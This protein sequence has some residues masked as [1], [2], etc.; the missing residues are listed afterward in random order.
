[1]KKFSSCMI[2]LIALSS[3]CF[4]KAIDEY[5]KEAKDH[6]E[7]GQYDQAIAT[8]EKAVKEYPKSS[9]AHFQ[10][11]LFIGEKIQ[12]MSDFG[13]MTVLFE[14]LFGAWAKAIALDPK[15]FKARMYRGIWAVSIPKFAGLLDQGIQDL[16]FLAQI[17]EKAPDPSAQKQLVT[18]YIHLADGYQKNG[19]Y[20]KA[21]GLFKKII[22][23][24]PGTEQAGNAKQS[25]DNIIAAEKWQTERRKKVKLDS[26]QVSELRKKLDAKPNNPDL[27]MAL[28]S[29]YFDAQDYETAREYLYNVIEIDSKNIT[30]YKLLAE[31]TQLVLS[32]EYDPRIHLDTDF[33]TDLAFEVAR[34]L[35]EAVTVAPHDI[36]LRL[37]RGIAGVNMPFFV[38]KLD[39]AIEDLKIV[40]ESDAPDSLKAESLYWLGFAYRKKSSTHWIK[41]VSK[42]SD[43]DAARLVFDEITP[44]VKRIDLTTYKTPLLVI[45]FILGFQDELA[46][47]TAVW[48]RD[49][50][51]N[52]VKTV[53][54]SGFSGYAKEQQ[55]NLPMWAHSS[56][57]ADVDAVTGASIDLG[58]HIYV[59]DL[60]NAS[61]KEVK[62]GEYEVLVEVSYWPSMQYQRVSAPIHLGRKE[63]RKVVKEGNLIPYLEVKYIP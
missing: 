42:Y 34:I 12:K 29:I 32:E 61:G 55:V 33:R 2:I 9:E 28:A 10:L 44:T 58:H 21:K 22:E 16:E 51:G 50:D 5:V 8:M 20:E 43:T 13:E 62:S 54:V 41:I 47:Q 45:D 14:K 63:A 19:E 15:N 59:W 26:S 18:V 6:Q 11:G 1:V 52:F 49:Q 56:K 3:L 53:Y 35:D 30:A 37:W 48:V 57:F 7:S 25:I 23:T 24:A 31:A 17:F 60:K 38:G 46:P 39:Q 27:L 4:G 36:E 40:M